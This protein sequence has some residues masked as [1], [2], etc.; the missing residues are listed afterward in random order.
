[1]DENLKFK[2]T[3]QTKFGKARIYNNK[4]YQIISSKEGNDKKYL[5]R[6]IAEDILGRK[7]K[8]DEDVHHKNGCSLDNRPEN[9]EVISKT[10]HRKLH[11]KEKNKTGIA[12]VIKV[13]DE[14]CQ[15]GFIW[16]YQK[17]MVVIGNIDLKKLEE[18]VNEKDLP[19]II[20]DKEKYKNSLKENMQNIANIK[21]KVRKHGIDR[22]KERYCLYYFRKQIKTS[23]SIEDLEKLRGELIEKFIKEETKK[24]N[25]V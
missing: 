1:M 21:I 19:W 20:L 24:L 9:L 15:Q 5:H 14:K 10:E 8:P 25:E 7:L 22:G 17:D 2:K 4:Y 13:K 11:Q 6:L 12:Y 23:Y 18:K 16:R 3:I